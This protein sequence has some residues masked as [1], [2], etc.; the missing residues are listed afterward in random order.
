MKFLNTMSLFFGWSCLSGLV[1]FAISNLFLLK[2]DLT[3]PTSEVETKS[4]YTQLEELNHIRNLSWPLEDH[5]SARLGAH[6]LQ[7]NS[8]LS[9]GKENKPLRPKPNQSKM[10]ASSLSKKA[11]QTRSTGSFKKTRRGKRAGKRVQRRAQ[12][13]S[14]TT[15]ESFFGDQVG[16][17]IYLNCE[18]EIT[19]ES[20]Q[21]VYSDDELGDD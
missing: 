12:R 5:L 14:Q 11:A 20:P 3:K 8:H 1:V 15:I 4:L 19:R 10:M 9:E 16:N 17:H 18:E 6:L 21:L 2:R 7:Q 13:Q